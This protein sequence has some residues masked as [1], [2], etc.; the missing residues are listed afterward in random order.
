[1]T[2]LEFDYKAYKKSM[3]NHY[4][5]YPTGRYRLCKRGDEYVLQK[6]MTEENGEIISKYWEDMPTYFDEDQDESENL[7]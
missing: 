4:M 3:K 5:V 6:E 7:D 1:M 2:I